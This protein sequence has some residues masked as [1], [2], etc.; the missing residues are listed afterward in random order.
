M[1]SRLGVGVRV[2]GSDLRH[3][4][5][6]RATQ[7]LRERTLTSLILLGSTVC[8]IHARLE[9]L[10]LQGISL[11]TLRNA[12]NISVKILM[13]MPPGLTVVSQQ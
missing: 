9:L 7:D 13:P 10:L 4:S 2:T 12:Q 3:P 8:S 1:A 5:D 11:T 6:L